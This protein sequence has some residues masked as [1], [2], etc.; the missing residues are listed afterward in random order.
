MNTT[1]GPTPEMNIRGGPDEEHL[2]GKPNR[3]G[4]NIAPFPAQETSEDIMQ[5]AETG[6]A[7]VAQEDPYDN[8]MAQA[9]ESPDDFGT[10][11][12]SPGAI[13]VRAPLDGE[14]V[15]CHP[16]FAPQFHIY[17][18]AITRRPFLVYKQFVPLLGTKSVRLHTMRMFVTPQLAHFMWPVK[19]GI[20]DSELSMI[21]A[22]SRDA[23]IAEA[24]KRWVSC[25]QTRGLWSTSP[26]LA[27]EIFP[28]PSWPEGDFNLWLKS[29]WRG[30]IIDR[31]DHEEIL[32]RQ[33]LK[34]A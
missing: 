21:Y 9:V 29:A 34:L 20:E 24:M 12:P 5:G 25:T 4:D 8:L 27:P 1:S 22:R 19:A 30:A 31:K 17:V 28:E 3:Q 15:R 11:K 33:G 23:V 26:P 6:F 7:R 10:G 32:I 16:L 2:A 18:N 14:F 13:V